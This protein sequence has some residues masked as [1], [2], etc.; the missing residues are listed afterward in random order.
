M[1]SI[2]EIQ[3]QLAFL[4]VFLAFGFAA[5]WFARHLALSVGKKP[6]ESSLYEVRGKFREDE[7]DV[8]TKMRFITGQIEQM[9]AASEAQ[10][11]SAELTAEK[12]RELYEYV[13]YNFFSDEIPE[14]LEN[15]TGLVRK[16]E[17]APVP[18]RQV[19]G[20]A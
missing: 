4:A 12:M 18:D 8:F 3:D 11:L 13:E 14:K 2:N 6:I 20:I 5:G 16:L 10:R 19:A 7:R 17:A 1:P 15:L 9:R